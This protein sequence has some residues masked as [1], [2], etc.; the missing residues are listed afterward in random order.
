MTEQRYHQYEFA[1]SVPETDRKAHERWLLEWGPRWI[2]D[3]SAECLEVD[4][5][6]ETE[7]TAYRIHVKIPTDV[8]AESVTTHREFYDRLDREVDDLTVE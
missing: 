5:T 1:Y 3:T 4:R 6:E 2:G 7:A 8:Y